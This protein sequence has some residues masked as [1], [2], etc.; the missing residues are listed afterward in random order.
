MRA[1]VL[2]AAMKAHGRVALWSES[3]QLL[4]MMYR[5]IGRPSVECTPE[6]PTP[7]GVMVMWLDETGLSADPVERNDRAI[8]LCRACG[9][10]V[11]DIAGTVVITGGAAPD[12]STRGLDDDLLEEIQMAMTA[13]AAEA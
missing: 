3:R 6:I 7:Y 13:V 4:P 9:Y 10:S 8:A 12:G 5:L 11:P 1:Y 2:P